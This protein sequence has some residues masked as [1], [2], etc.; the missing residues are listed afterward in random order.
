MDD[1][2]SPLDLVE[3]RERRDTLVA[4][5]ECLT[6][7]QRQA[8]YLRYWEGRSDRELE[9]LLGLGQASGARGLLQTARR[10][11]KSLLANER[12]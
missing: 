9:R 10:R 5:F 2:P 8:L 11:L 3:A 12:A 6:S 1:G 7:D 4:A